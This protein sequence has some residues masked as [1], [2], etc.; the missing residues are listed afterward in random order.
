MSEKLLHVRAVYGDEMIDSEPGAALVVV[1]TVFD[2]PVP[3]EGKKPQGGDVQGMFTV[4]DT[5]CL[6]PVGIA[7]LQAL[8]DA[9][10][11]EDAVEAFN[12]LQEARGASEEMERAMGGAPE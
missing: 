1:C 9:G 6:L 10:I 4:L 7:A 3:R 11:L 8:E 5:R 2:T 12:G